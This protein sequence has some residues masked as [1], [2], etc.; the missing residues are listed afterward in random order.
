MNKIR[1]IIHIQCD[2]I[3]ELLFAQFKVFPSNQTISNLETIF[4]LRSRN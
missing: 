2:L 1:D 3:R 4:V